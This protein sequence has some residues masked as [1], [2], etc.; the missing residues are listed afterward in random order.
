MHPNVPYGLLELKV[1]VKIL[2]YF[3]HK[4]SDLLVSFTLEKK[5]KNIHKRM[6]KYRAPFFQFGNK[7]CFVGHLI[8]SAI[9]H[10]K[11]STRGRENENVKILTRLGIPE[12]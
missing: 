12:R 11:F 4:L 5:M 9:L 10:E 6:F 7:I 3:L 2:A 1:I 8:R